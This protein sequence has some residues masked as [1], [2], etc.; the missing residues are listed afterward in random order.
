MMH[1][2]KV[3]YSEPTSITDTPPVH[4]CYETTYIHTSILVLI[5]ISLVMFEV[6][7]IPPLVVHPG[8]IC[9]RSPASSRK[10]IPFAP[11]PRQISGVD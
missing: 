11:S 4:V 5:D 6:L 10:P 2:V 9:S 8:T 7:A 1:S 3:R